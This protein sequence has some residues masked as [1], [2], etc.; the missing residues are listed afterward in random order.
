[1]CTPEETH[2]YMCIDTT[3]VLKKAANW[4]NEETHTYMC[5]DTVHKLQTLEDC[6]L[7]ETHTYM[8]IDT[9]LNF[10]FFIF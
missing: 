4:I 1:M 6:D 7:E 9:I 2:T 3:V 10:L 8:C 5:I